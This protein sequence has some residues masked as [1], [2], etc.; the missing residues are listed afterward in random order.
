MIVNENFF[1]D[2]L[3][4]DTYLEARG[5]SKDG[6]RTGGI[7]D[8]RKVVIPAGTVLGRF[9][10]SAKGRYGQWWWTMAEMDTI[11][12]YFGRYGTDPDAGGFGTGRKEGKGIVQG[13]LAVRADW[14]ESGSTVAEHME[15]FCFGRTTCE[16]MA[17]Y[18]DGDVA[19]SADQR[20][21]LKPVQIAD[22][23][24]TRRGARQLYLP[25]LWTYD[26]AITII[27][28]G[29][30]DSDLLAALTRQSN[31]ALYFET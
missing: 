1:N 3:Y 6:S 18:G 10:Q 24:G 15:H 14:R 25:K 5:F 17:F 19:P 2:P 29:A 23:S 11:V 20:S 4:R 27:E 30:S 16:V 13:T 7:V 21:V 26:K 12:A 31:G 9:F 8:P 22:A 28:E